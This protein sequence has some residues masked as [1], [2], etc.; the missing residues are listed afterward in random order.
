MEEPPAWP[1]N[2]ES[3]PRSRGSHEWGAEWTLVS[4][5]VDS[6]KKS[7]LIAHT[8][9]N[10]SPSIFF[11][12]PSNA[13]HPDAP[14]LKS[15]PRR[16]SAL[17]PPIELRAGAA[18]I[19][20]REGLDTDAERRSE[21]LKA[22]GFNGRAGSKK[23]RST[24]LIQ[25][26]HTT[27]RDQIQPNR[28]REQCGRTGPRLPSRSSESHR[29]ARE[30]ESARFAGVAGLERRRERGRRRKDVS[31]ERSKRRGADRATRSAP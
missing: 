16:N 19:C 12:P 14:I 23:P 17:A 27:P 31:R 30:A 8:T 6:R 1:E 2:L 29:Q 13:S 21:E 22:A 15:N 20:R 3:F 26:N 9:P 10:Q 4:L 11:L 7:F 5:Q 25:H 24:V 18:P 28:T